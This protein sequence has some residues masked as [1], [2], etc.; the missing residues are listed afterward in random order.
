LQEEQT[1]ISTMEKGHNGMGRNPFSHLEKPIHR[2]DQ[3]AMDPNHPINHDPAANPP[4]S[5]TS[6]M[7]D[8]PPNPAVHSE[9]NIPDRFELFILGEGE[10]KITEAPDTRKYIYQQLIV[11]TPLSDTHRSI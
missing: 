7:H 10:K 4:F 5:K 1:N 3:A 9:V 8:G 11:T 6:G 2:V